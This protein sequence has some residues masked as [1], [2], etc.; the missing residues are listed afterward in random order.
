MAEKALT[1][2]EASEGDVV[3]APKLLEIILQNCR[4]RVDHCVGPFIT[5]ALARS[6]FF[7]R[8]AFSHP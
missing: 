5:L 6:V 2:E 8:P 7:H 3:S 1:D 4:G